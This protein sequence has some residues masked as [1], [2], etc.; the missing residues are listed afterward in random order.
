[1]LGELRAARPIYNKSLKIKRINPHTK[2]KILDSIGLAG[3][4]GG[5]PDK[6]KKAETV[7]VVEVKQSWY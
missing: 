6:K 4:V 1:M 3:V 7:T 2:T 5:P